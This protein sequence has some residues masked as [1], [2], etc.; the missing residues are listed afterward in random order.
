M[1]PCPS[2]IMAAEQAAAAVSRNENSSMR[3]EK[4]WRKDEAI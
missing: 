1:V 4:M 3:D 2:T